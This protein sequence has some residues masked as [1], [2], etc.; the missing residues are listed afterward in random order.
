[1]TWDLLDFGLTGL[2]LT[3]V[4]GLH[5]GVVCLGPEPPVYDLKRSGLSLERLDSERV[6]NIGFVWELLKCLFVCHGY[7]HCCS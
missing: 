7:L 5:L 3:L 4:I 2:D 6:L 1:M